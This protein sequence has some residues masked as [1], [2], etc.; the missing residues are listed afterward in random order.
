MSNWKS[1]LNDDPTDWLLEETNP[2]VRYFALRW[3]L[4][5]PEGSTEVAKTK[6][7]I[8][9]SAPVQKIIEQQRPGGYWGAD[10]RPHHGT[11]GPLMLLM[12]LGA[13]PNDSIKLA[14]DY[15]I[16]GCLSENG[17]Y[18]VRIWGRRVWLPCHGAELL[19]LM[20]WY[21]YADDPRSRNLLHWLV[22]VQESDGVWPC[23]SK[24]KPFPCMW[25]TADALRAFRDIPSS[26]TTAGVVESRNRA[27]ELFL[28]SNLCQYRKRKPSPE[29]F[30]F[31]FPLLYTSDI[32]EV[33]EL[34][35]PYV[36]PA[37]KR[38]RQGLDLV[39]NKQDRKG[40]WPNE[41]HPR[42]GKWIEKYVDLEEIGEPSKWVTLHAMRMLKILYAGRTTSNR[43]D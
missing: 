31:G 36:S 10:P 43:G 1:L 17:A 28:N 6:H 38:I 23:I 9:K 14:M 7:A 19:R 29:W 4:A 32:L 2:S 37:D 12:W 25:A 5:K 34:I 22:S 41:K 15:R 3:L 39:L 30:R 33:L 42:A 16:D 40:R 11:R 13:P 8:A 26:W 20:L 24:A 35:A 27:V 21:G 18:G